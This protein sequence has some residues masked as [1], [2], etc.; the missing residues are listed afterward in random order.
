MF[1]KFNRLYNDI[2]VI[3]NKANLIDYRNILDVTQD[4]YYIAKKNI[5]T[6]KMDDYSPPSDSNV[7]YSASNLHEVTFVY[8]S[9]CSNKAVKFVLNNLPNLERIHI[10]NCN[11][12]ELPPLPD[13][14]KELNIYKCHK[15]REL[16]ISNCVN[17][18]CLKLNSCQALIDNVNNHNML[19]PNVKKINFEYI[20]IN[21]NNLVFPLTYKLTDIY[22]KDTYFTNFDKLYNNSLIILLLD[23]T[24]L[25]SLDSKLPKVVNKIIIN[26]NVYLNKLNMDNMP[27]YMRDIELSNNN[28]IYLDTTS[29]DMALNIKLIQLYPIHKDNKKILA[30]HNINKHQIKYCEAINNTGINIL[31]SDCTN[32]IINHDSFL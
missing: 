9:K 1:K 21:C 19:P 28:L 22:I 10:Y 4:K 16:N 13:T 30:Q 17:M 29:L 11:M 3:I 26:N 20:S 12:C 25:I 24:G 31:N 18:E 2:K 15:L 23:N 8:L 27:M 5:N 14:V 7:T 32:K 6:E